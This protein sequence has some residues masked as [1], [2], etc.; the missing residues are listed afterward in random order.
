MSSAALALKSEP[1]LEQ[2]LGLC[3][4]ALR[5][6]AAYELDPALDDRLRALGERKEWLDKGEHEELMSL[7]TF[8]EKRTVE[9]LEA[10][11]ALTRLGEILPEVV[12]QP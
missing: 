11:V 7:V 10:Q 5:R 6:I 1:G 3:V 9:K 4:S 8:T 2:A 12:K